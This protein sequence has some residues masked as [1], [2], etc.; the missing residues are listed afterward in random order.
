VVLPLVTRDGL[1]ERAKEIRELLKGGGL[2]VEYEDKGS[3]G[4]RYA[5]HDEIGTPVAVTVDYQT[6]EDDS[7][8][9]RDRDSW[10][11]VRQ[12]VSRLPGLLTDYLRGRIEF[13]ELGSPI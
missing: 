12:K 4:K 6:L 2:V 7:V 13:E 8:T 10:R 5:R 9:L 3:I 11:Q 1:P